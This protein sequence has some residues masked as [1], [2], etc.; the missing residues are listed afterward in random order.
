MK[1]SGIIHD[2][3]FK[4]AIFRGSIL[5]TILSFY[6]MDNQSLVV[7][8]E[9]LLYQG[10]TG[11]VKVKVRVEN[12]TVWLTLN[13]IAALF[14]KDKSTISR[15][16]SNI[17]ID[18]ELFPDSTVVKNATVQ[19]EGS[20]EV[21]RTV[22]YYNLDLVLSVGY[23]VSSR[24]A[25]Q[26]RMW[27]T[28]VLRNYILKG[29]VLNQRRLRDKG[30]K[31]FEEAVGLIKRTIETRNLTNDESRGLLD[32]ITTYS[33]TWL[34]LQQY[35]SDLLKAPK[36]KLSDKVL[37]YNFCKSAIEAL[38][39]DLMARK[40][41]SDL[42][43]KERGGQFHGAL[44]AIRQTFDT[45]DLYPSIEEKA[46][47]LLYF[48]IKDHPFVDGNKRI[49]SFMFIVF[50]SM[51]GYLYRKNGER[52]INDNALVALALLIAESDPKQKPLMV[53][54]VMHFLSEG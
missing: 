15:H 49:G 22:E 1:M 13:Q 20:R 28:S 23:R 32:V 3:R 43:G 35:D 5:N 34:L 50:L 31:E 41:A 54:L 45:L 40:E 19:K 2:F 33:S 6:R 37:E 27:A 10:S 17:Y 14:D 11:E 51:H 48:I 29:Y 46:A 9:F 7:V 8:S 4:Q 30:L 26:F 12:D 36:T 42:F 25:T 47:H 16:I 18:Q 39:L 52:K 53:L 21:L 24:K 44:G 38:K